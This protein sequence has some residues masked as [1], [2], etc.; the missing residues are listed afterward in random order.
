MGKVGRT[1][2]KIGKGVGSALGMTWDS[3]GLSDARRA[4][5][6]WNSLNVPNLRTDTMVRDEGTQPYQQGAL[7]SFS[8]MSRD[9]YTDIDRQAMDQLR[10]ESMQADSSQRAA[11]LEN[12]RRRGAG[13]GG[14]NVM[15]S[16]QA[17]QDVRNQGAMQ[18]LGIAAQGQDRRMQATQNM[19]DEAAR[20]R[21]ANEQISQFN[22]AN[23]RDDQQQNF[24]NQVAKVQGQA[25]G[26]VNVGQARTAKQG[27]LA[28]T[29][30]SAV[31]MA[32]MSD[33]RAKD[34]VAP[35]HKEIEDMFDKVKPVSFEYKEKPGKRYMSVM[36]QDLEK[37]SAGKDL[38]VE[39][40]AGMKGIDV[41]QAVGALM[42]AQKVIFERLK[43]SE[44]K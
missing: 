36:A 17:G 41:P 14:A 8:Q 6:Y 34:K 43:K 19:G 9:G 5:G 10:R 22:I 15:A 31:T 33:K 39:D 20:Q 35:A 4:E 11:A 38:V 25:G 26:A 30:G 13:Q 37:S 44:K 23:K 1:F 24:N 7:D 29:I 3:G 27:M 16:L 40:E 42:A 32:A 12:V 21:Q 28:N 18:S 2:K